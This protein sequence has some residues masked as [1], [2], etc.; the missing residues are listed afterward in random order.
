L[1]KFT[2]QQEF[3]FE[4]SSMET[5]SEVGSNLEPQGESWLPKQL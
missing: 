3:G 2:A 4:E 5:S 1:N